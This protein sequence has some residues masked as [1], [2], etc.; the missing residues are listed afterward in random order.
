MLRYAWDCV[1]SKETAEFCAKA[2]SANT[3][4]TAEGAQDPES[5]HYF[6]LLPVP[7]DTLT[8]VDDRICSGFT[9]YYTVFGEDFQKGIPFPANPEHLEFA[10]DF[11]VHASALIASGTFKPAR[12]FANHGG[13][14]LEGVLAGL[15]ELKEGKVSGGKLVYTV[16]PSAKPA[17]A[18]KAAEAPKEGDKAPEEKQSF[19][20]TLARFFS[21]FTP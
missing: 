12:V 17:E 8:A 14:G 3:P 19:L 5:L 6:S 1:S 16:A 7:A 2:L 11:W 20:K 13:A 10:R 21:C 4:R 18:T 15:Q 9:L